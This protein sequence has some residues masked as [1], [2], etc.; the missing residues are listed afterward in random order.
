MAFI[1]CIVLHYLEQMS[2]LNLCYKKL[3]GS[4]IFIVF[5]FNSKGSL[6]ELTFF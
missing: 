6:S 1:L 3:K 4:L 5:I 2:Q